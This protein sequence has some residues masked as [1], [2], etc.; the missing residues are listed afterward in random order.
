MQTS[1]WSQVAA[2]FSP[3]VVTCSSGHPRALVRRFAA[4]NEPD[5]SVLVVWQTV[6][7]RPAPQDGTDEEGRPR[8]ALECP[9]CP[10]RVVFRHA[11]LVRVLRG[12]AAAGSVDGKGRV[13]LE[14]AALTF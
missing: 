2:D 10:Q 7:G 13:R 11:T 1:V 14:L 5:G 3:A 6:V 12:C 9:R 8:Y 4:R